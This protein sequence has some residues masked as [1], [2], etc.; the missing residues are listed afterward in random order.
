MS[1]IDDSS[2][3]TNS[4]LN[5]AH[6]E[7]VN[8]VLAAINEQVNSRSQSPHPPPDCSPPDRNRHRSQKSELSQS[9]TLKGSDEFSPLRPIERQPSV[10]PTSSLDSLEQCH[11]SYFRGTGTPKDSPD[12]IRNQNIGTDLKVVYNK[13]PT[14]QKPQEAS[15]VI[16]VG[17]QSATDNSAAAI[18]DL[19]AKK[20]RS[21]LY[22]VPRSISH[23]DE[24][25]LRNPKH[26]PTSRDLPYRTASAGSLLD[27]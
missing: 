27:K 19:P 10:K 16:S 21:L 25:S 22:K 20:N 8:D 13:P 17:S 5:M 15:E 18:K 4:L 3:Y 7:N 11:P 24:A 9:S 14:G 6:P 26:V 23:T 12:M 2:M 1:D